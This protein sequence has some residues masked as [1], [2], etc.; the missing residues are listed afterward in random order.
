MKADR[1]N[2]RELTEREWFDYAPRACLR[3]RSK[4]ETTRVEIKS[5]PLQIRNAERSLVFVEVT[6]GG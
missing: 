2:D 4:D 6:H 5:T 1:D 3:N